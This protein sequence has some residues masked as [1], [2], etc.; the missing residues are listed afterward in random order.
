MPLK[1][2]QPLY[3][4]IWGICP[5]PPPALWCLPGL[6]CLAW[7]GCCPGPSPSPSLGPTAALLSCGEYHDASYSHF[8]EPIL[9]A[10]QHEVPLQSEA[11]D[12][13]CHL[14]TSRKRKG[15]EVARS[16]NVRERVVTQVHIPY[17]RPPAPLPKEVMFSA[18]LQPLTSGK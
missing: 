7:P 16:E 18:N 5:P 12:K 2:P 9:S 8:M 6:P 4:S 10:V 15:F 17:H 3:A 1:Q 14:N 13:K 11:Q